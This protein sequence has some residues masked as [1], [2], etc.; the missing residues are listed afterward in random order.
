MR[1]GPTTDPPRNIAAGWLGVPVPPPVKQRRR[2]HRKTARRRGP[3]SGKSRPK[4][5]AQ[6]QLPLAELS[7]VPGDSL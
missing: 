6:L 1:V 4:R 2:P 5:E 7:E 3:P